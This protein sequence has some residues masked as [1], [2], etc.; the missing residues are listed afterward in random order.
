MSVEQAT[1]RDEQV[2]PP[3]APRNE[4][5]WLALIL[6]M[7]AVLRIL[8]FS[9]FQKQV[10][11][12]FAELTELDNHTW[13]VFGQRIAAGDL[14][15][16]D[17]FNPLHIWAARI[18]TAEEW[19]SWYGGPAAFYQAPLYGY[20]V[21]AIYAVA[22]VD[23]AHVYAVQ[24][25]LGLLRVLLVY[26]I[27]RRL[28]GSP[29]PLVAAFLSAVYSPAL[30]FE[31]T[32]LRE[33]LLVILHLLVVLAVIRAAQDRRLRWWG[34]AG[35]LGGME[36]LGKPSVYFLVTFLLLLWIERPWKRRI[37][38]AA[39]YVALFLIPLGGLAARNLAVGQP[40]L[41]NCTRGPI[42]FISGNAPDSRTGGP[43]GFDVPPSSRE[44]LRETRNAFL[45][46]VAEVLRRNLDDPMGYLRKLASK[47]RAFWRDYEVPNNVHYHHIRNSLGLL[48]LPFSSFGFIL[49]L[50]AVGIA[51]TWSRRRRLLPLYVYGAT[52]F[53]TAVAFIVLARF[54]LAILPHLILFASAGLVWTAKVVA[55]RDGKRIAGAVALIFLVMIASGRPQGWAPDMMSSRL[56]LQNL[57]L[58]RDYR[59][60]MDPGVKR[61]VTFAEARKALY[62]V[63]WDYENG[64]YADCL[65]PLLEV[66]QSYPDL[67]YTRYTLARCYFELYLQDSSRANYLAR[68][69]EELDEVLRRE[70]D[71]PYARGLVDALRRLRE[72][73]PAAALRPALP[74]DWEPASLACL[75]T[76]CGEDRST[77]APGAKAEDKW[78]S[79]SISF[80][81]PAPAAFGYLAGE[82]FVALADS[83]AVSHRVGVP[84]D[85]VVA[86]AFAPEGAQAAPARVPFAMFLDRSRSV[87][88]G[89]SVRP[90]VA[91]D[92]FGRAV[93]MFDLDGDELAETEVEIEADYPSGFLPDTCD[94]D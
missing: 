45:P 78:L 40:I 41:Q 53:L 68:A 82:D 30:F 73:V 24:L 87:P 18:G 94:E 62:A 80:K 70:P 13:H 4:R 29:V 88:A 50:A 36:L 74:G 85:M 23:T 81:G 49:P 77:W 46:T 16:R 31:L 43:V 33:T 86:W 55:R 27:A 22:G 76:I 34:I 65:E 52:T 5:L 84:P 47:A 56:Y 57:A 79:L 93:L 32:L 9:D 20:F 38:A 51:V 89:F 2:R 15:Y 91:G 12:D 44:I 64:R 90:Q 42:T 59:E 3:H 71:P 6:L 48:R 69:R 21:G 75:R 8:V 66:L 14:L 63:K 11:V 61:E 83:G 54:R 72:K 37:H 26:L 17:A 35:F 28:F 1:K 60:Q 25:M 10:A 67:V 7:A 39:V 19:I 58:Y 92:F